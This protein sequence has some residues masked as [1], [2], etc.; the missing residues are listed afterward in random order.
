MKK[1]ES[2]QPTCNNSNKFSHVNDKL[3]TVA[4]YEDADDDDQ[5]GPD[6]NISLLSFA[7]RGQPF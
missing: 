3:E 1:I 2:L 7:Q 6:D 4:D 5:D